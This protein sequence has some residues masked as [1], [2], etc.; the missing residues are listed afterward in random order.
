MYQPLAWQETPTAKRKSART[1]RNS[2]NEAA[3]DRQQ[4]VE[5]L[6]PVVD[7][8]PNRAVLRPNYC[9]I[10]LVELTQQVIAIFLRQEEQDVL[11]TGWR[12]RVYD[13][14]RAVWERR[15]ESTAMGEQ[16]IKL[17]AH[18]RRLRVRQIIAALNY[19]AGSIL[20][21][22]TAEPLGKTHTCDWYGK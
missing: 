17:Y 1:D 10:L 22:Q 15:G 7:S 2:P 18:R 6:G 9:S 12:T 16:I 8:C 14:R 20:W 13:R 3:D 4:R 11:G 19:F 21:R 5:H